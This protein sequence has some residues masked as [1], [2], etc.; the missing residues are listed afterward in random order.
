ML[1]GAFNFS[2]LGVIIMI[3]APGIAQVAYQN[4]KWP[5]VVIKDLN[6]TRKDIS[7]SVLNASLR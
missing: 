5:L 2:H 7:N 1:L 6:I 4:W 3:L